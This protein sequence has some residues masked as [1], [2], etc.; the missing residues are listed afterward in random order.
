M[1]VTRRHPHLKIEEPL[2]VF[3]IDVFIAPVIY[4]FKEF[5]DVIVVTSCHLLLD[6]FLLTSELKLLMDKFGE[7]SLYIEGKEVFLGDRVGGSLGRCGSQVR[8]VARQKNLE[9]TSR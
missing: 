4:F 7:G 2:K 9:V 8:L 6:E 1:L 5:L 3:M